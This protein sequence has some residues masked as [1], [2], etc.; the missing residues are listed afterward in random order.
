MIDPAK[1][2]ILLVDDEEGI[3][4]TLSALL[5][6]E[7]YQVDVAVGHVDAV[8]CLKSSRYD[9]VF[10]DIMLA[11]ENGIDVLQDIKTLS[12][13]TEVVMF[14]GCPE[15]NSAVEAVRL[16]AFDYITKPVQPQTLFSICR[17]ALRA[18][19][20]RDDE[21]KY[22]AHLDAIF[23]SVS[24]SIIMVDRE[25]R[26]AHF[27]ITAAHTC[28]YTTEM[29]GSEIAKIGFGCGGECR[30]AL[31]ETL[32]T[33]VS[34]DLRR[35]ECRTSEGKSCIVSFKSSPINDADGAM[36]GAVA[37]IRDETTIVELE[38]SLMKRGQFN[39][40]IGISDP[41]QRVYGLIESLADVPTTVLIN[42]E[43]G[44]G[45]ELV[46]AALHF[47]GGR[48]K[49]PFVKVNCSALSESLLESELFGHVRGAFT[50]ATADKIGRFQMAHRGTLFLDEIGDISPAVQMR[51]LRVLQEREFERVGDST[52]IK[53]DVRI[54]TATNQNLSEKVAQG[55]FRQDLYYRLNVVRMELPPLR[56]RAEDINLLAA[57]FLTK[58]NLKFSKNIQAFSDDVLQMFRLHLWPG[59]VRELEHA[60]EHAVILS[61]NNIITEQYLPQD[62]IDSVKGVRPLSSKPA[63]R[64]S[65]VEA[66][67]MCN[68]NITH[69]AR[70]LGVSRP[71]VYRYMKELENS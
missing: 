71:T 67:A 43:S 68:G 70:L 44:T 32:R 51:L 34:R 63:H 5:K 57:H 10:V 41:M 24:D 3:R 56:E 38:R 1:C 60:V 49:G 53:V 39:N 26:L 2:R 33:N 40:I 11:G 45:K 62:L 4:F 58:F 37:V 21:E 61:K 13:A 35:F 6:R 17:L 52:S 20:I 48:A 65:L 69:A 55:T 46:A 9:L 27:N 22:R 64:P 19:K 15:V 42:G 18:K 50:G 30:S 47:A 12:P 8:V 7:G 23:R 16:G 54:V 29:I 66:M 59:N 25:G 28:G 36:S 31:M 14:T